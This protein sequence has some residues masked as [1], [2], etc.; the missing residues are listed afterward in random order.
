MNGEKKGH[1]LKIQNINILCSR[2]MDD[3]C[4]QD[5]ITQTKPNK[6]KQQQK[7]NQQKLCLPFLR[8]QL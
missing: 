6:Q 1:I 8:E 2:I 7:K 5:Q 3:F 4:N